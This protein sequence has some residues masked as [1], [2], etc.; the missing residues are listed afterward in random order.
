MVRAL[1]KAWVEAD[2]GGGW[3]RKPGTPADE[4]LTEPQAAARM[5]EL[6]REHDEEQTRL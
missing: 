2:G 5:L 3:K 4:A 6:V 1:G